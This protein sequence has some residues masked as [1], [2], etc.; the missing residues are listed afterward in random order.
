MKICPSF[1]VLKCGICFLVSECHCLIYLFIYIFMLLVEVGE[2]EEHL[3]LCGF[4]VF[5][6]LHSGNSLSP[7]EQGI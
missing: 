2:E 1:S 5:Q 4:K 6:T 3:H 7:F